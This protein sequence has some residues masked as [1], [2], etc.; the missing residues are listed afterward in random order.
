MLVRACRTFA[1]LLALAAGVPGG[2]FGQA[3]AGV[4]HD[5][6]GAAVPDVAVKAESSAL[7][8]RVRTVVTDGRGQ[9]RIEDLRP[10][11]YTVSF[12]RTGFRPYVRWDGMGSG[13]RAPSRPAS[14]PDSPRAS[15]RKRSR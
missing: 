6:S 10:G 1:I 5:A 7:I 4:V 11:T 12:T 13:S 9:Y 14:T 8:E 3:I 2:A 15:S